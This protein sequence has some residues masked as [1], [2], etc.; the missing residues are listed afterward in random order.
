M[1]TPPLGTE[2]EVSY[3]CAHRLPLPTQKVENSLPRP[4]LI[5]FSPPRDLSKEIPSARLD[6]L[7]RMLCTLDPPTLLTSLISIIFHA[8]AAL[9]IA[10]KCAPMV[11]PKSKPLFPFNLPFHVPPSLST[12]PPLVS[13]FSLLPFYWTLI[14]KPSCHVTSV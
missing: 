12:K 7:P 4:A 6:P 14:F 2:L 5:H 10:D 3:S 9:L 1:S 13:S 11:T 8:P